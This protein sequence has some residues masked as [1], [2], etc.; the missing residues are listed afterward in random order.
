MCRSRIGQGFNFNCDTMKGYNIQLLDPRWQK[1]RLKIMERDGFACRSCS[2]THKTLHVHHNYYSEGRAPWEYR[3][4]AL[5]TLCDECHKEEEL[6]KHHLD[7]MLPFFV[8]Q[9]GGLN[10]DV[11]QLCA[12]INDITDQGDDM[13]GIPL[14]LNELDKLWTERRRMRQ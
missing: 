13:A 8:R 9:G 10:S 6:S 5:F 4:S 12:L 3:D 1:K 2:A 11:Q 7:E 14:I